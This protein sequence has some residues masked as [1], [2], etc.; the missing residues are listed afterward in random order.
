[1]KQKSSLTNGLE[2]SCA[3]ESHG[4]LDELPRVNEFCSRPGGAGISGVGVTGSNICW[5]AVLMAVVFVW[6]PP[7]F[8][9]TPPS[10]RLHVDHFSWTFKEGAPA[11]VACLA[12]TKDG[13]LWLGGP[14]GLFR[15]DGTRFEAF[16]SPFGDRLLSTDLY[17]LFAP[18]SGGPLVG[19]HGWGLQF[20][21]QWAAHKLWRRDRECLQF[22]PGSRWN[23]MGR[24]VEWSVEVRSFGL[25]AYRG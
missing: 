9:Q 14:N 10:A 23:C 7:S 1:M 12:Q 21:Q 19:L 8:G 20:P 22:C 4:G 2:P 3:V 17:S 25:A 6:A 18:L 15:F 11:D 5:I 13:L 16:R 24:R